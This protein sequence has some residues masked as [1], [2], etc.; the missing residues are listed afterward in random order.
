M[1]RAPHGQ[2]AAMT[3]PE[4]TPLQDDSPLMRQYLGIKERYPEHLLLFRMGDFYE[5]FNEDAKVMAR[6]L[7]VTLTQ[8]GTRGKDG[9]PIPLA[10][11]PYHALESYLAKLMRGGLKVAICEQLEDPKLAKGI[12]KRDVVRVVSPGTLLEDELLDERASNWLVALW[13]EEEEPPVIATEGPS[14]VGLAGHAPGA[15]P[16]NRRSLESWGL[17]AADMSSGRLRL[18]EFRGKR[19]RTELRDELARLQPAEVLLP[20]SLALAP[21]D[22]L[23]PQLGATVARASDDDFRDRSARESLRRQL[24]VHDLS[25]FGAEDQTLSIRASGAL[26]RYLRAAQQRDAQNI[27]TLEVMRHGGRMRLDAATQRS[28]ELVQPL[29]HQ[30]RKT[31]HGTL[32]GVLDRCVTAMGGRLLREWLLEPL[33]DASGINAR[34]DAVEA[35]CRADGPRERLA[36][37][38]RGVFDL[39]RIASRAAAGLAS[40]RDLVALRATLRVLP[41]LLDA[42]SEPARASS[43]LGVL[44]DTI[45]DR[46]HATEQLRDALLRGL[47]DA[48][49]NGFKEG[50]LIRPGYHAGLDELNEVARGSKDWIA[51]MRGDEVER[52]GIDSLKIGYN[53]VFGY[54]IEVTR[55]QLL[56]TPAPPHWERRQTLANA[57]RFITPELKEKEEIIL[58]AEERSFA[59]EERLFLELR[60]MA[61][62][63]VRELHI[64]S[65]A[66]ANLDALLGLAR[67]ALTA[68]YT[69]PEVVES[70]ARLEIVGGRHPVLEAVAPDPTQPFVPNDTELDPDGCR[71]MLI[72]GPN[73]AGKSTYIRQVALIALMAHVGSFVPAQRAR[74]GTLDRIFTR[75]GAMDYLTRG[76]STFLVEMS[77]TANILNNCTDRSLV[78]LDEIGRG[79][80]TYDGLSIAWAVVEYLHQRQGRQA[81]TLFATHYHELANLPQHL[82]HARNFNVAVLEEEDRITFLYRIVPGSTDRSYGIF[83]ARLGGMPKVAVERARQILAE[84]ETGQAV[85][86]RGPSAD[87]PKSLQGPSVQLTLFDPPPP[88]PVV[89]DLRHLDL[90]RLSPMEALQKLAEWKKRI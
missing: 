72:T 74:M 40:P 75:V 2:S 4:V 12:V 55:A 37:A 49:P 79:T 7:G 43:L 33:C 59:L 9:P 28:L 80:S 62:G 73:M 87:L 67:T 65:A 46:H 69:R 53:R 20:E 16:Y 1:A 22:V 27:T 34:L 31:T 35:I 23:D 13:R 64:L 25:G 38:L 48:P 32:L 66:L 56:K 45:N 78:I 50:G 51:R 26:L 8:R 60:E 19:S 24:G 11:I 44:G 57:E 15:P 42:L 10:G 89:E 63:A 86:V 85:E 83:A 6:V 88:H 52:T 41:E 36:E 5:T 21:A 14:G 61:A 54:F 90:N 18:A 17:A 71:I 39:Q 58:H 77:E 47:V 3:A 70:D 84:L 68:G 82:A 29:H 81:K 30:S 76:Q